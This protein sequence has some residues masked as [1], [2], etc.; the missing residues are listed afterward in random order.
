MILFL[1]NIHKH[2]KFKQKLHLNSLQLTS[3]HYVFTGTSSLTKLKYHLDGVK[4]FDSN[5]QFS[6]FLWSLLKS[7]SFKSRWSHTWNHKHNM[8]KCCYFTAM[9]AITYAL[10]FLSLCLFI[11]L[12]VFSLIGM[13]KCQCHS[14][15]NDIW[16]Y[17]YK[18]MFTTYSTK[19]RFLLF[20]L[21]NQNQYFLPSE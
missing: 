2:I 12:C 3:N 1:I 7:L 17:V 8:C 19:E 5:T 11:S 16:K 18:H 21:P 14:Y 6:D 20:L 9:I 4:S 13:S 15:R 10:T